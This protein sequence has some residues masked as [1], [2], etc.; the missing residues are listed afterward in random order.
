M[1]PGVFYRKYYYWFDPDEGTCSRLLGLVGRKGDIF[2]LGECYD[3]GE[4]RTTVVAALED[5]LKD[6]TDFVDLLAGTLGSILA[7]INGLEGLCSHIRV[8]P[9]VE[10]A[11]RLLF[12]LKNEIADEKMFQDDAGLKV[13]DAVFAG[14]GWDDQGFRWTKEDLSDEDEAEQ[15]FLVDLNTGRPV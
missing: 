6:V 5:E 14:H 12:D 2:R 13:F 3:S 9:H 15:V 4:P 7:T 11:R 8:E 1:T 10:G